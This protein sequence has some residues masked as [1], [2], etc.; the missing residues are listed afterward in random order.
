MAADYS[1]RVP[2][3]EYED[4]EGVKVKT[5]PRIRHKL[6]KGYFYKTDADIIHSES[7]PVETFLAFHHNRNTPKLI[8]VQDLRTYNERHSLFFEGGETYSIEWSLPSASML[9]MYWLTWFMAKQ[10]IHNAN[11]VAC[12][13]HLLE[14]KVNEIFG[15]NRKMGFLPNFIDIPNK[16]Y[17]KF[18]KPSVVWLGRLDHVKHPELMFALAK[19]MPHVDFYVL[20]HSH[21]PDRQRWYEKHYGNGQLTNVHLLGHV[22][23][24]AK[25]EV[26]SKCWVLLNTSF[27]EC[28]PISFLEALANHCALLSTRNPDYYT[29]RFGYFDSSNSVEGLKV[30]LE[31]LL[32]DDLWRVKAQNGFDFVKTFHS[33][34]IG[35]QNHLEIYRRLV[36]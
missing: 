25:A 27:Y 20:G 4:I 9:P 16:L 33:T 29:E 22:E 11:L 19:C 24:K 31:Y 12:Q 23:G 34:E 7:C 21:F 13:A 10:N 5:L 2:V 17:K 6:T 8:T 36:E 28:L 32:R 26:L 35:V 30:G 14:P 3:G 1:K 15:Y 18:D